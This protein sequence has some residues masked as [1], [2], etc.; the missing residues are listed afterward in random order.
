MHSVQT[1]RTKYGL[2]TLWTQTCLWTVRWWARR[3]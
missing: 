1:T 3:L 2:H